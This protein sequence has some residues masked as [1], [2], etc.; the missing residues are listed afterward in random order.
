M[1]QRIEPFCSTWL[2]DLNP[3]FFS[4]WLTVLNP[5]F[6]TLTHRNWMHFLNMSQRIEPFFFQEIS[7]RIEPIEKM[8]QR[9]EPFFPNCSMNLIFFLNILKELNPFFE[10]DSKNWTPFSS[11]VTRR[12]EPLFPLMWLEELN[13]LFSL[14]WLKR[15][16][17]IFEYDSQSN[18]FI[19]FKELNIFRKSNSKT[20]FSFWKLNFSLEIFSNNRSLIFWKRVQELD[21]FFLACDSKNTFCQIWLEWNFFL[22]NITHRVELFLSMTQGIVFFKKKTHLKELNTF[23]IWI[24]PFF[25]EYDQRVGFFLYYDAKLAHRIEL[26]FFQICLELNS[27]FFQNMTQTIELFLKI[28][29]KEIELLL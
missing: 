18:F 20:L 1:T 10:Y 5:W 21:L 8:T 19:W 14:M 22:A 26:F 9:I 25:L 24:Q 12:I 28:W 6:S 11:Y 16:W 23:R 2:K 3:S 13:T 15:I 7:Q 17:T 27:F 29:L 4:T